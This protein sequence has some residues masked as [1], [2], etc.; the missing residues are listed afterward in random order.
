MDSYGNIIWKKKR[1]KQYE[2]HRNVIDIIMEQIKAKYDGLCQLISTL[3]CL[4]PF[5]D[6]PS[7]DPEICRDTNS[8]KTSN[9]PCQRRARAKAPAGLLDSL[10]QS[11]I[12]MLSL[13]LWSFTSYK[14]L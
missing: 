6:E 3:N 9:A 2:D 1:R 8:S 5:Q 7:R 4:K 10:C 14:Y 12:T 13:Q 11:S